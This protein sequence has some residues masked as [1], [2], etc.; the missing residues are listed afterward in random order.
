MTNTTEPAE[1]SGNQARRPCLA[2]GAALVAVSAFGGAVGLVA[3]AVSL[4]PEVD[5]RLPFGS[6]RFSG[7][8]LAA[9]VG[10]PFSVVSVMAWRG[11]RRSG[12]ASVGAGAAL[13]VWIV[14]QLA[15]IR[16]V[17]PFQPVFAAIGALFVVAGRRPTSQPDVNLGA[18]R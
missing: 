2:T 5:R 17:S 4:G 1:R 8:A 11:D 13:V 18:S 15:F 7:A 3:E 14:V 16:R 6:R 10:V 12:S 9:V